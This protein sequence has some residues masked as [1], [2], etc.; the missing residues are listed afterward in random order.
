MGIFCYRKRDKFSDL[1]E[2][3]LSDTERERTLEHP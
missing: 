1:L 2:D 3:R